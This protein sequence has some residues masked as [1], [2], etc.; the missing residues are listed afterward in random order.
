M[1]VNEDGGAVTLKAIATTDRDET[2]PSDFSFDAAVNTAD[3]TAQATADYVPPADATVTFDQSDF[4]RKLTSSGYRY[5]ATE[6]FNVTIV[7]DGVDETDETFTATLDYAET[8]ASNL[9]GGNSVATVTIRDDEQVPVTLGWLDDAVSVNESSSAARLNATATTTSDKRPENGFSFQATVITSPGTADA[10]D[11][12]THVST[13][14]TFQQSD[15]RSAT[16]DGNRRYRATKSVS[17]PILNDRADER[18]ESFTAT[19]DY[20]DPNP[21]HLQGGPA[22]AT[23]TIVDNDLPTVSIERV[24]ASAREDQ[25]LQFRLT[26]EGV[27]DDALTANVRVSETRRMLASGQ[28]ATATFNANSSTITLDVA[29]DD[30]TQDEDSSVVT[31]TVQSG[32]GYVIGMESSAQATAL[33]ND[34]VPVTLSWDPDAITVADGAGAV[35]LRGV[36]TTTKDKQ[37]ESGFSFVAEVTFADG[38]ADSNDYFAQTQRRTFSQSDF[39][40]R[41]QRYRATREFTVNIASGGGD[42]AD[43]TFTA[44]L[45]YVGSDP[46][47]AHRGGD[48]QWRPLR[49]FGHR[50]YRYGGQ[51]RAGDF[52]H[53]NLHS[54]RGPG[55]HRRYLHRNRPGGSEH[56]G[57]QLAHVRPRRRRLHHH[58]GRSAFLPQHPRLR[59]AS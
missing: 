11:D 59:P 44:T 19:V 43:E 46:L 51:R 55:T 28:P 47:P 14:V 53:D 56:R 57:V 4:V 40:R 52:R 38:T 5:H 21:L 20:V 50:R 10:T 36:A 25:S 45:A 48:G 6:E 42:E 33:D 27:A 16:V 3:G 30:D 2:V 37:P 34:H 58:T 29:L 17:V 1:D 22:T 35:T 8:D 32:S 9:L 54:G 15:F 49:Q 24:T 18:D 13:T 31:A 12:Y 41:G 39:A 23:V 7:S 26:R